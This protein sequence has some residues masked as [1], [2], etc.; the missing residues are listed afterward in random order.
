MALVVAYLGEKLRKISKNT[1][2]TVAALSAY[3]NEVCFLKN[4]NQPQ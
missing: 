1:N 2:L 3:L 4:D